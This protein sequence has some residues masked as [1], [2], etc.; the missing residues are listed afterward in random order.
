[1]TGQ[2]W[3]CLVCPVWLVCP[4]VAG[5]PGVV[6]VPGVPG[7]FGGAGDGVVAAF[8]TS[9]LVGARSQAIANSVQ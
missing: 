8:A 3:A 9:E 4:V 1:M 2:G 7:V 5:V 6:G